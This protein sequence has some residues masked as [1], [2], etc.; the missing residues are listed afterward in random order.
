[1]RLIDADVEINKISAEI[2]RYEAK[3]ER[4]K[5]RRSQEPHNTYHNWNN[6]INQV[7]RNISEAKR[8]IKILKAYPTAYDVDK[9]VDRLE[10]EKGE[11]ADYMNPTGKMLVRHWNTC[12]D[13]CKEIMKGAVKDE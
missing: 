8:E 3:L 2:E 6:E 11:E 5:T 12:V 4:L 13:N 7:E 1:M 10:K 9:V